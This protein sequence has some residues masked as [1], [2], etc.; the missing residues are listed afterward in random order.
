MTWTSTKFPSHA[1]FLLHKRLP[2]VFIPLVCLQDPNPCAQ[3]RVNTNSFALQFLTRRS[4]EVCARNPGWRV[5]GFQ[6]CLFFQV[7]ETCFPLGFLTARWEW[8]QV[9]LGHTLQWFLSPRNSPT[10]DITMSVHLTTLFIRAGKCWLQGLYA[11]ST[12]W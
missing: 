1:P 3:G 12:N 6:L 5:R 9:F 7:M 10:V 4:K 2:L 8:Y 11:M